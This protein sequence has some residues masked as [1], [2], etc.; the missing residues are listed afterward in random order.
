MSRGEAVILIA[1]ADDGLA[2]LIIRNLKSAGL[3]NR[4][5]RFK[6]GG[7]VLDYLVGHGNGGDGPPIGSFVLLLDNRLPVVDG[8]EVLRRV[9]AS[10][11][12]RRM[13]VIMLT[14]D[15]DPQGIQWW[16]DIGCNCCVTKPADSERFAEVLTALGR[17][18]GLAEVPYLPPVG[19]PH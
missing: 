10:Q 5:V 9:K 15:S 2:E 3:M 13:P 8:V 16:Q 11:R 18:L 17:F 12:L 19:E 1:E 14:T 7:E 4:V 6:N